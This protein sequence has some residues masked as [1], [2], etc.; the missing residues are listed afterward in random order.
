MFKLHPFIKKGGNFKKI[1]FQ[2]CNT[3]GNVEISSR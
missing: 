2:A 3:Q 1:I